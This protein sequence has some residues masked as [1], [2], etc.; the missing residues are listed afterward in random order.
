MKKIVMLLF[1]V[2]VLVSSCI[3]K[4]ND[5]PTETEKQMVP[6][7]MTW[8]IDS[9]LVVRDIHSPTQTSE[10]LYPSEGLIE[11]SYTFYPCTY[12]F[13]KDLCFTNEMSGETTYMY[14]EYNK[15]YC[16]YICTYQNEVIS[17]GYLCYYNSYFT[18]NGLQQGGWVEFM[19]REANTQWDVPVWTVA[20]DASVSPD[21][22]VLERC[23]E[24]YSRV[25]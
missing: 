25:K 2:V 3:E 20:Y 15:N 18:F 5:T 23:Y 10:M 12:Q 17:A 9:M 19:M 14:K 13:P 11:W 16:K 24:F 21:G 8:K 6:T 7:E 22:F 4:F 1:L